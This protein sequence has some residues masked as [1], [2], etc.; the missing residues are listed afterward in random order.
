MRLQP[1]IELIQWIMEMINQL[2]YPDYD[3]KIEIYILIDYAFRFFLIRMYK[4]A[5]IEIKISMIQ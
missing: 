1:C 5:Y 3:I 4:C 2:L